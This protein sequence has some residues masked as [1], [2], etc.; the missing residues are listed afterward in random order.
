MALPFA[1]KTKKTVVL[2]SYIN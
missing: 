1:I 2:L